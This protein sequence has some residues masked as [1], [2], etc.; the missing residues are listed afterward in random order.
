M[1]LPYNTTWPERMGALAGQPNFF[2]PKIWKSL[3]KGVWMNANDFIDKLKALSNED[4]SKINDVLPKLHTFRMDEGKS[5]E[6]GVEIRMNIYNPTGADFQFVPV[7]KLESIQ[8]IEIIWTDSGSLL[9]RS[10]NVYIDGTKHIG[11]YDEKEKSFRDRVEVG[12]SL[13]ELAWNEGFDTVADF[14][15]YYNTDCKLN[16]IHWTDLKY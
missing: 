14:F 10:A 5:Y 3:T 11:K 7:V 2:V 6:P 13:E 9:G 8:K 4:Q 15:S 12:R 16:I 1:T